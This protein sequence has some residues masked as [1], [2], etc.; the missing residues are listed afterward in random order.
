M[1]SCGTVD[2]TWRKASE[3][4]GK[5]S[6]TCTRRTKGRR[7]DTAVL[8]RRVADQG[9]PS[10]PYGWTPLQPTIRSIRVVAACSSLHRIRV[11]IS[12]VRTPSRCS[13]TTDATRASVAPSP[14]VRL[15][16][17]LPATWATTESLKN[18]GTSFEISNAWHRGI[19]QRICSFPPSDRFPFQPVFRS[20]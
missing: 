8:L 2:G 3:A 15:H 10:W 1:A 6:N 12:V 13:F 11:R 14:R 17:R 18:T 16:V 19:D 7:D 5:R 9:R 4:G 20:F